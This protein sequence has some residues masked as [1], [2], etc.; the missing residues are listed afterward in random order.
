MQTVS[1]IL[2]TTLSPSELKSD[3]ENTF[4]FD[5]EAEVSKPSD[6]SEDLRR[7]ISETAQLGIKVDHIHNKTDQ[8]IARLEKVIEEVAKND[9]IFRSYSSRFKNQKHASDSE[10]S[11]NAQ[12]MSLSQLHGRYDHD[13]KQRINKWFRK[14]KSKSA[15]RSTSDLRVTNDYNE[16][17]LHGQ[18]LEEGST[19]YS[20]ET[21]GFMK[22]LNIISPL[23][24]EDFDNDDTCVKIDEA[25]Q[26][27][28]ASDSNK[29]SLSPTFGNHTSKELVSNE[30]ESIISEPPLQ[31]NKKTMLKYRNVRTSF[32]T[33]SSEKVSSKNNSGVF[34]IFHRNANIGDKNQENVPRVWDV[35]KDNLGREIYL[36]Q[37]RFKKWTAKHQDARKDP[38]LKHEAVAIPLSLSDPRTGTQL[39]S[40]FCSMSGAEAQ[41]PVQV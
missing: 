33:M 30:T 15:L 18:L 36:L 1:G 6:K 40:K 29:P 39:E 5:E 4:Q 10:D 27:N 41:T 11:V 38:N 22:G 8:E 31:E 28:A 17:E 14:N 19:P 25:N 20:S 37:E 16:L 34:R 13:W 12:L 35:V 7:L 3:D 24:P 23:T 32:N 2:P 9:S 21:D 26:I